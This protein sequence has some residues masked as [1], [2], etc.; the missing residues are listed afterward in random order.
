[1]SRTRYQ[2]P[3][4]NGV[5]FQKIISTI[6]LIVFVCINIKSQAHSFNQAEPI[7]DY[8]DLSGQVLNMQA[9][10]TFESWPGCPVSITDAN[11]VNFI[12]GGDSV[13]FEINVSNCVQNFGIHFGVFE[14]P[15]SINYGINEPYLSPGILGSAITACTYSNSPIGP[16]SS[17]TFS[18]PTI[19]GKFYGFLF[20][21]WGGDLCDVSIDVLEGTSYTFFDSTHIVFPQIIESTG[22]YSNDSA[23]ILDTLKVSVSTIDTSIYYKWYVD[24]IHVSSGIDDT[25][26]TVRFEEMGTYEI[27]YTRAVFCDTTE[28]ICKYIEIGSCGINYIT[29]STSVQVLPDV[30]NGNIIIKGDLT[31]YE[32]DILDINESQINN[33]NNLQTEL[34]IP[35]STI[36]NSGL[37]FI[38]IRHVINS[39]IRV[40]RII[41]N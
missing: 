24:G 18:I 20:D 6:F 41:M 38:V 9:H 28:I 33:F 35:Y 23:C 27:C 10:G 39:N 34:V 36:P 26:I 4:A 29:D 5:K 40:Q 13:K 11:W 16:G 21:S 3:L 7:C 37:Y 8:N 12:G 32:V 17:V 14:L 19:K 31:D 15:D 22:D 1:M 30:H 2:M 25:V